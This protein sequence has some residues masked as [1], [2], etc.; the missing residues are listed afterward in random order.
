MCVLLLD[1]NYWCIKGAVCNPYFCQIQRISAHGPLAVRSVCVLSGVHTQ[2]WLC[3]QETNREAQTETHNSCSCL[4]VFKH[5]LRIFTAP[6]VS[7]EE[8]F[9]NW[10]VKINKYSLCLGHTH[11]W[12]NL[13]RSVF[14]K[15]HT[16]TMLKTTA[17]YTANSWVIN[18]RKSQIKR[19]ITSNQ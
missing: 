16:H 14:V 13:V 6:S 3:K 19:S 2:S 18:W 11:S 4:F 9:H 17:A 10:C 12:T 5:N 8:Q 7:G 15:L 1:Y